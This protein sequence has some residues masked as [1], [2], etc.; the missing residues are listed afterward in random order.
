MIGRLSG[1]V[2]IAIGLALITF[3][4]EYSIHM[5]HAHTVIF[6]HGH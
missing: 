5:G 4:V 1:P 2:R 6:T 3:A